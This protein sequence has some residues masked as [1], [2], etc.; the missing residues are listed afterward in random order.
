VLPDV[1]RKA[2]EDIASLIIA[3]GCLVP[4]TQH[5]RLPGWRSVAR[6]AHA[7]LAGGLG[8]AHPGRQISGP[9]HRAE[10]ETGQRARPALRQQP[11]GLPSYATIQP[12][13]TPARARP[14]SGQPPPIPA[15]QTTRRK[16]RKPSSERV[17]RPGLEPGT[18]GLKALIRS[19]RTACTNVSGICPESTRC[20]PSSLALVPRAVPRHRRYTGPDSSPSVAF[21]VWR[22]TPQRQWRWPCAR[23]AMADRPSRIIGLRRTMHGRTGVTSVTLTQC[24][25]SPT[26]VL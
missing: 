16:R 10:R 18:H 8:V 1:A 2:A 14:H 5:R 22:S 12:A 15:S 4:G 23:S 19:E 20:T 24:W 26:L 17:G 3:A 25:K 21:R 11:A 7:I 6:R 9:H 13:A